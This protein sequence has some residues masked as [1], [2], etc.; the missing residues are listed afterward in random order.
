[1]TRYISCSKFAILKS[2]LLIL[3]LITTIAVMSSGLKGSFFFDDISNIVEN[4]HIQIKELSLSS[5]HGSIKG[6]VA[7]PLGRPVSVLSFAITYYFFG[8]DAFSFKAV[9]LLIHLLNGLLVAWLIHLLLINAS[10]KVTPIIRN[11]LP[12]WVAIAW[13]LHPINNLPVMLAVQRMTLLSG[14]FLLLGLITQLVALNSTGKKK[15]VLACMAWLVFW[16]LAVLSKETGL[17]FPLYVLVVSFFLLGKTFL[18]KRVLLWGLIGLLLVIAVAAMNYLGWSWLSQAYEVRTFTL[19]ERLMTEARVLW[20]YAAQIIAPRFSAFAIYL[21]EFAVS[22]SLFKPLSTII[23][24]AGWAVIVLGIYCYR[25]K[26]P[27]L[28]F[29]IAWFIAGHSLESTFL[30]LEIA[31]EYRNYMPSIGLILGI[32]FIGGTFLSRLK[33]DYKK[34]FTVLIAVIPLLILS[35]FTWMRADQI[36]QPLLSSQIEASRHPASPRANFAAAHTLF[37]AGF[38]D[39]NDSIGAQQ[40]RYYFLESSSLD[41]SFKHGHLGLIVWSCASGRPVDTAWIDELTHRLQ[42]TPFSPGDRKLPHDLLDHLLHMPTCLSRDQALRLF[43]SG[44]NNRKLDNV[45]RAD[46][47]EAASNYELL[48]SLNPSSA[49]NYLSKAAELVPEDHQLNRKLKSFGSH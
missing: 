28:C 6:P 31:H 48:V 40:V 26:W 22:K 36:G 13:L 1:M 15:W 11:W 44:S 4:E 47:L 42:H 30:P 3:G 21:D 35:L 33:A 10:Q 45:L 16:P 38:G 19:A 17:L 49:K 46:F 27:V 43:E 37:K 12:I 24:I 2:C 7:G 23:S 32:G 18:S 20:F 25:S 9:N 39:Q 29:G 8:L 41:K 5:L 34:T 14:T